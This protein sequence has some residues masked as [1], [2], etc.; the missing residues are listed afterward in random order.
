V[1]ISEDEARNAVEM[2]DMFVV[3][4]SMSLPIRNVPLGRDWVSLGKPLP[5]GFRYSSSNN[6]QWLTIEQ[7][8]SMIAPIESAYELGT[9]E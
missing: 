7:I 5:D 9:L 8:K 1:L 2:E 4:P 3:M 6:P